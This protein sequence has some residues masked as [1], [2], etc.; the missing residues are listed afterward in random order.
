MGEMPPYN[1]PEQDDS[2]TEARMLSAESIRQAIHR[3]PF[4]PFRLRAADGMDYD[5][6]HP[7]CLLFSGSSRSL[8]LANGHDGF[9]FLEVLLISAVV[10][11]DVPQDAA[12]PETMDAPDRPTGG[13]TPN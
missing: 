11:P 1:V 2:N 6:P 13:D 8:V 12:A 10:Y 9:A 3:K 5:V 7:E 4:R